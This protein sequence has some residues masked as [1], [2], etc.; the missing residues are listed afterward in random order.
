MLLNM[1]QRKTNTHI[2][3]MTKNRSKRDVSDAQETMGGVPLSGQETSSAVAKPSESVT[4]SEKAAPQQADRERQEH[5]VAVDEV[6]PRSASENPDMFGE[7]V[8]GQA[9]SGTET[10]KQGVPDIVYHQDAQGRW[11]PGKGPD[12]TKQMA[13]HWNA[14]KKEYKVVSSGGQAPADTPDTNPATGGGNPVALQPTTAGKQQTSTVPGD[15]G[16]VKPSVVGEKPSSPNGDLPADT[17]AP[18]LAQPT[19]PKATEL[20]G[21]EPLKPFGSGA[22]TATATSPQPGPNQPGTG[23]STDSKDNTSTTTTTAPAASFPD[24]GNALGI[25]G[26]PATGGGESP[27]QDS[28][29]T[30]TDTA[31]TPAAPTPADAPDSLALPVNSIAEQPQAPAP[32]P[33]ASS[34]T[35]GTGALSWDSLK[36]PLHVPGS[37]SIGQGTLPAAAPAPA[38]HAA[39]TPPSAAPMEAPALGSVF[40]RI[41]PRVG[42]TRARPLLRRRWR[43]C[44]IG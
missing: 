21:P 27:A 14:E 3:A 17:K 36:N 25:G 29:G 5:P 35:S 38:S 40:K 7:S 15:L 39:L 33:A 37:A 18:T 12:G 44:H 24:D 41:L 19:G 23:T 26:M 32:A 2:D 1:L 9:S 16:E 10:A 6:P 4:A 43:S 34:P 13:Y 11:Q 30:V 42:M 8:S 28:A 20:S 22:G 31:S